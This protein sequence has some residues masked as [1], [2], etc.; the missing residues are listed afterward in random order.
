MSVDSLLRY[1]PA[2]RSDLLG[3]ILW[4]LARKGWRGT[5]HLQSGD[6][7]WSLTLS[8]TTV[9]GIDLWQ[10]DDLKLG[11]LLALSGRAGAG[12]A[13]NAARLAKAQCRLA[14]QVLAD[15]GLSRRLL[16]QTL[17]EQARLR[18]SR[19]MDQARGRLYLEHGASLPV[20]ST[21][22]RPLGLAEALRSWARGGPTPPKH[23]AAH[24]R[25]G[26]IWHILRPAQQALAPED[27]VALAPEDFVSRIGP[28]VS[29]GRLSAQDMDSPDLQA[30]LCLLE[31]LGVAA[32]AVHGRQRQGSEHKPLDSL[33]GP[34]R[35]AP[36]NER[37]SHDK[38]VETQRAD[39]PT[40]D[41]RDE[42]ALRRW[43]HE[44]ARRYHPDSNPNA[45]E[46]AF[47]RVRERYLQALHRLRKQA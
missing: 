7:H 38:K 32:R 5:V 36:G 46:D 31:R 2:G 27:I 10:D 15:Q 39:I 16:A 29:F 42:K 6:R 26:G 23:E 44:M 18:F 45:D 24:L 40:P 28:A 4:L 34:G 20:R 47:C 25:T 22:G 41:V 9:R 3:R 13:D 37:R 33:P 30:W 8:G 19:F 1:V 17:R 14:G 21:L 35:T 11:R 12:R 43:W